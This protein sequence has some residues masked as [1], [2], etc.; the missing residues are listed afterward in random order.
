MQRDEPS[1]YY[2]PLIAE[3]PPTQATAPGDPPRA[4]WDFQRRPSSTDRRPAAESGIGSEVWLSLL[5]ADDVWDRL[6]DPAVERE[7]SRPVQ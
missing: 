1:T 5:S 2:R 4:L 7:A 6:V 3:I